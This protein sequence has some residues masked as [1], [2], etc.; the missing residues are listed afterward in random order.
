M[1]LRVVVDFGLCEAN[2][3]CMQVAPQVFRVGDDDRLTVLVERPGQELEEAVATAAALCPR[4]AIALVE[5]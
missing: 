3:R 4:Q 5:E 1:G 2:A